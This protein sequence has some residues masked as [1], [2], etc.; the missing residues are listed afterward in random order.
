MVNK[1]RLVVNTCKGSLLP[2]GPGP[3]ADPSQL[4]LDV[5]F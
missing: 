4:P 1:L 2:V 5:V 3:E